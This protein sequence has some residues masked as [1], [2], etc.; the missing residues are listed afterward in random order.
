MRREQ[1]RRVQWQTILFSMFILSTAGA[2]QMGCSDQLI[3]LD[4]SALV[5]QQANENIAVQV[6]KY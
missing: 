5:T 6:A 3:G 4:E 2:I 1:T